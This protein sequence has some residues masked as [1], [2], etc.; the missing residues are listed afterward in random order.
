MGTERLQRII[1][2]ESIEALRE[3]P[4]YGVMPPLAGHGRSSVPSILEKV[5]AKGQE[6]VLLAEPNNDVTV[7]DLMMPESAGVP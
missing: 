4:W 1:L 7:S 5:S 3:A 2:M 6:T